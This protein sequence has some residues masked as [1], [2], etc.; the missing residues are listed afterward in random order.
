[1]PILA[2]ASP[3]SVVSEGIKL[4]ALFGAT[5]VSIASFLVANKVRQELDKVLKEKGG[6]IEQIDDLQKVQRAQGI[7]LATMEQQ[8]ED[9]DRRIGQLEEDSRTNFRRR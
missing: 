1:L 3:G 6:V 5:I 8:G 7:K 4:W 9:R 2:Q